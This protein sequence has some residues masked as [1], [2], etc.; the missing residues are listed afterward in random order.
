V[1]ELDGE[2][3]QGHEHYD[4]ARTEKL[5]EFGYRVIRFRNQDVFDD[6]DSVLGRILQAAREA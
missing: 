4:N 5:I 3:H 6:L 2:V 1:I